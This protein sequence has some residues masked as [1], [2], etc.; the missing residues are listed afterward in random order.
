VS[1]LLDLTHTSH[2]RA[3]TGVQRV[4]RA[5]RRALGEEADAVCFDPYEGAWRPVEAWEARNL[6]AEGPGAGR[7][8]RWPLDARFRGR[9]RRWLGRPS[10]LPALAP[11][12]GAWPGG[13][14]VPEIFSP[15]VASGLPGLFAVSSGPRVAVFHDAIALQY[16]EFTAR[17]TAARFPGYLRDLLGFDGIAAVSEASRESLIGYWRWLG[18]SKAPP[19]AAIP[20]GLDPP[21]PARETRSPAATPTVLCVGS[22]EG[23]KNHA[24]LLDACESLWARGVKFKL[25][26]VGIA[27]AETGGPAL[28][29]LSRLRAAGRP[30]RYDGP[31]DDEG[32]EAAYR[33]CAFTVY[34]SLAEG[35]GLPV[36]ESLARG[37]PCICRSSGALGEI[38][39][40][41]GCMGL[42]AAE[43]AEIAAA[44]GQLIDFPPVLA[45]LEARA[46]E[47]RFKTWGDY[48]AELLS[49]MGALEKHA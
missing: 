18:V 16:P 34:P 3:R 33:E 15:A 45:A 23:R 20:L 11:A 4:A 24:A 26:L 28:E 14:L 13:V 41:G 31:E 10:P 42:G 5:L 19:V 21:S 25:R 17:S 22:I 6:A 32:L 49:W 48:A 47:R 38:A 1:L 7:G 29:R 12:A 35:Y 9:M 46:R 40:G 37:K 39:L 27:N 44:I 36:A 43:P 30:V 2:T 8:A